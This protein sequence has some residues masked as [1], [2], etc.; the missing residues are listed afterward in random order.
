MKQNTKH[1]SLW[2]RLGA[3]ALCTAAVWLFGAVIGPT[4]QHKIPFMDQIVETADEQD[5]D[6]G[7]YFYTEIE[8]SY[9]GE[10]YLRDTLQFSKPNGAGGFTWSF[11]SAV[12]ICLVL[13]VL[14][15]RYLPN[16]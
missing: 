10:R 4:L 15:F 13:L 1:Q 5:I 6:M 14:G 8:A 11:I 16:D 3:L 2:R 9:D 12:V 7:A